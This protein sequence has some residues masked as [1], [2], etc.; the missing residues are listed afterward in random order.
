MLVN[1]GGL[2]EKYTLKSIKANACKLSMY[3]KVIEIYYYFNTLVTEC[4]SI[5]CK[6]IIFDLFYV[7]TEVNQNT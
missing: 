2:H 5:T 1:I 7:W 6:V 4:T 3:V